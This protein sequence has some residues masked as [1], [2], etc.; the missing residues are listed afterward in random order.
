H[1]IQEAYKANL[2]I[3]KTDL[4]DIGWVK[5]FQNSYGEAT[6]QFIIDNIE[7]WQQQGFVSNKQFNEQY[8]SFGNDL[9]IPAKYRLSS[10]RMNAAIMD[11]CKK[12][13]INFKPSELIKINS[14][15]TRGRQFGDNS[16][17]EK[18]EDVP[19]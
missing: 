16:G 17:D 2:K 3:E 4:S 19:F 18:N 12:K 9:D 14:I 10:Q 7:Q 8:Q 13:N 1:C 5:Q 15:P 11:Y 6:H